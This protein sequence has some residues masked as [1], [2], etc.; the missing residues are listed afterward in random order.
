MKAFHTI[1]VPHKDIL[2]G[3]F[4]LNVYAANLWEVYHQTGPI[5][6][7]NSE[8]FF[9][10]TYL[11]KE[12]GN[13]LT[14]VENRINGKGGDPVIQLQTPFGGGKTHTLIA[15]FHKASEWEARPVVIVGEEL[16]AGASIG[17]FDTPW[18]ITTDRENS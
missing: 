8:E 1:S 9:K 15:L 12:L 3:N 11:T 17:D 18:G 14:I 5:E 10:K 7:H 2:E 4:T 6:Y 16:N 13:L